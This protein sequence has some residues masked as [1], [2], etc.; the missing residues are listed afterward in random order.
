MAPWLSLEKELWGWN[1]IDS[2]GLHQI[3]KAEALRALYPHNNF[4]RSSRFGLARVHLSELSGPEPII[5]IES[6]LQSHSGVRAPQATVMCQQ[7]ICRSHDCSHDEVRDLLYQQVLLPM[8]HTVCLFLNDL[9][10]TDDT[11]VIQKLLV[12][13]QVPSNGID[14][15]RTPQPHVIVVLTKG[16]ERR[17][18]GESIARLLSSA[19]VPHIAAAI[20]VVDLRDRGELSRVS[21]FQPLKHAVTRQQEAARTIRAEAR[22]LFSATHLNA[23]ARRS[24]EHAAQRPTTPLDYIQVSRPSQT[25][26][27]CA[28][29]HLHSFLKL[30]DD[31]GLERQ[32]VAK[33]VASAMLMNA[34]PPG[35]HGFDPISMFRTLY[36]NDCRTA[37]Q[38]WPP[39]PANAFR[40][41]VEREFAVLFAALQQA[42]GS[43]K[44]RASVLRQA[45]STWCTVKP[46]DFCLFCLRQPPVHVLPC[47]H[48]ICDTCAN[49]FGNPNA[50]AEY[51]VELV[52]CRL[53]QAPFSFVIRFLPPTKRPTLLVLDGGG[54]RGVVT[55]GYL[56]ALEDKLGDKQGLREI[57]D[58]TVGTSAGA[59]IAAEMMIR[60]TRAKDAQLKFKALARQIFRARRQWHTFFGQWWE[61]VTTWLADSRH[62]SRV[63]EDTL[64]DAFGSNQM[65]FDT[66]APMSSGT[67]VALTA[68]READGALCLLGNYRAIRHP[69]DAAYNVPV[70]RQEPMLWEVYVCVF[71]AAGTGLVLPNNAN[72]NRYFT[73]KCIPGVGMLQ[74]GGVTANCPLRAALRESQ[75][76][77]PRCIKP[78]LVVSIGTGYSPERANSDG[79]E[80]CPKPRGGFIAR[81]IRTFLS[82]SAV[83]GRRG[84]L[85][86]WD[87]VPEAIRPDVFRLDRAITGSLPELDDSD[88]IETLEPY[89]YRVPEDL[90][91]AWLAK[92]FFFELDETPTVGPHGL[93]CRGSILCVRSNVTTLICRILSHFPGARFVDENRD[94]GAVS[95][96]DGCS[97]CG[98]FRKRVCLHVSGL[99]ADLQLGI[100][101]STEFRTLGGFPTSVQALLKHQ[102]ADAA[103]G[104]ADHGRDLWPPTRRCYCKSFKRTRKDILED[105]ETR[106]RRRIARY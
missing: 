34:Y 17:V 56:A 105:H 49:I 57:F 31:T 85:D 88:A 8:T 79:E 90:T 38:T 75:I 50:G 84:W 24:L 35:M 89:R 59:V 93:A 68:S 16:P 41:A 64:R 73:P 92:S 95:N 43:A 4:G 25:K 58:L 37:C 12:A 47:G 51:R 27:V 39:S 65:L 9:S 44:L 97:E 102:Q 20:S 13:W 33:C 87:S 3:T 99:E 91:R 101:G 45:A 15:C 66:A 14:K 96:T 70:A 94:M 61:F 77:W 54:V 72:V 78:D 55:L 36:A 76:I 2:D 104:R 106:K 100:C 98:Y 46:S 1:L 5:L 11:E 42:P 60:G 22:L 86:A 74:D 53:C 63:L 62:D 19:T 69:A 32:Y 29:K 83:D 67:R 7:A 18:S 52:G 28:A 6:S 82:S 103:F 23:L 80:S 40:Q 21:R 71:F 26:E 48:T 10:S 30:A 81:A